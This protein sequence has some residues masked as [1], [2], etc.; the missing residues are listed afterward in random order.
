M[1][2]RASKNISAPIQLGIDKLDAEIGV[3][4]NPVVIKQI[5][6]TFVPLGIWSM[7]FASFDTIRISAETLFGEN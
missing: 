3:F 2:I 1:N 7:A 6:K 4:S 5:F